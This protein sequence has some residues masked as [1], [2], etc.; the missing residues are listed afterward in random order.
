MAKDMSERMS[1]D[2]SER[3]TEDMS[4]DM[5]ERCQK[6]CQKICQKECH[7]ICPK[8]QEFMFAP[9]ESCGWHFAFCLMWHTAASTVGSTFFCARK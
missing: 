7:K 5:S 8:E 3:M 9:T 2:M 1:E 6:E 4:E